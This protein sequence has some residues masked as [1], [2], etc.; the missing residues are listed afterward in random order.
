M[1]LHIISLWNCERPLPQL[2][3]RGLLAELRPIDEVFETVWRPRHLIIIRV[4]E[5]E[6]YFFRQNN[7]TLLEGL[8]FFIIRREKCPHLL[9]HLSN[10]KQALHKLVIIIHISLTN[11]CNLSCVLYVF[12]PVCELHFYVFIYKGGNCGVRGMPRL[13][14]LCFHKSLIRINCYPGSL[15]LYKIGIHEQL[16]YFNWHSMLKNENYCNK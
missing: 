6:K 12:F 4:R 2:W 7:L 16:G 8:S 9:I 1:S 3:R 15:C 13:F 5:G 11:R 10:L 14:L